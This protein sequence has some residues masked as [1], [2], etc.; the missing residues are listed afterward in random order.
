MKVSIKWFFV[1]TVVLAAV[2]V[3]QTS[4][5]SQS[6]GTLKWT[7]TGSCSGTGSCTVTA[8]WLPSAFSNTNYT[9]TCTAVNALY[10]SSLS[11]ISETASQI[12]VQIL[13]TTNNGN[14]VNATNISCIAV[15]N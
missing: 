8:S 1:T 11:I 6:A 2:L 14:I 13:D 12:E 3:F 5:H 4:L 9:A 7:N 15:H 10:N